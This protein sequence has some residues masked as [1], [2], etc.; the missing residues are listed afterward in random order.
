MYFFACQ[1]T[2]SLV[3]PYMDL[4]RAEIHP[5]IPIIL[6]LQWNESVKNHFAQLGMMT[7]YSAYYKYDTILSAKSRADNVEKW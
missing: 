5:E 3:F 1:F 2:Y 4:R 7:V 6:K